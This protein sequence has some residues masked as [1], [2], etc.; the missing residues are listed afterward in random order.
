[1]V[2]YGSLKNSISGLTFPPPGDI[3]DPGTDPMSPVAPALQAGSL[4]LSH[5]ERPVFLSFLFAGFI[6]I[7]KIELLKLHS[8]GDLSKAE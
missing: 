7:L 5:W 2:V 4:P 1:M 3:P 8:S 6:P